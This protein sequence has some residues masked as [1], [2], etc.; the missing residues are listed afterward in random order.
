MLTAEDLQAQ[1]RLIA[2]LSEMT[3]EEVIEAHRRA[4]RLYEARH[5]AGEDAEEPRVRSQIL[6]S[7][8]A[9]RLAFGP[10]PLAG[11]VAAHEG[12]GI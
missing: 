9:D 1:D 8:L 2:A 5:W 7:E 3:L 11:G 12:E 4:R 10:Q 6:A